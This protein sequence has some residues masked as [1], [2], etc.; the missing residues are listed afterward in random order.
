[1]PVRVQIVTEL[2]HFVDVFPAKV[3]RDRDPAIRAGGTPAE[4][5]HP[6]PPKPDFGIS[7]PGGSSGDG[8]GRGTRDL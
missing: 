1:M 7:G 3:G 6:N 5:R 8:A 4:N 2:E